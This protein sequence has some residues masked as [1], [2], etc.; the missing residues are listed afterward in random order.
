MPSI[1]PVRR[2]VLHRVKSGGLGLQT[3]LAAFWEFENTSWTDVLG[4]NNLTG[5][6]APTS[7]SSAPIKVG[8]YVQLTSASTQYLA[9]VSNSTLQVG[10]VDFSIAFWAYADTLVDGAVTISKAVG[11]ANQEFIISNV[12]SGGNHFV[13]TPV[14]NGGATGNAVTASNFGALSTA[15]WYFVVC[16]YNNSTNTA[17]ISVNAGTPNTLVTTA[18]PIANSTADFRIG[19][20]GAGAN[21]WNGR[22]DQVGLWKNRVLSSTDITNLYNGNAGLSYAAMV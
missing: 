1:I 18:P 20:D 19:V 13:F 5:N 9:H 7:A 6:G 2:N 8:N 15:T 21:L 4:A 22:V 16:T 10:G 3:N 14:T 17:A 12:F 11:F